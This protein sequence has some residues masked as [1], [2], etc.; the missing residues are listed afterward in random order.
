[1]NNFKKSID[2]QVPRIIEKLGFWLNPVIL[3]FRSQKSKL[4]IFYFHGIY[5]DLQEKKKHHVAPQN[6]IT[7]DQ[8]SEFIE[9][10]LKYKYQFIS[11]KDL[12]GGISKDHRYIM[13]TFD[14]GYFNNTLAL[15]ALKK[16]KVPATFFITTNNLINNQ[17]FWWD[18]VYK[19]RQREGTPL[20]YIQKEQQYLKRFKYQDINKYL[21]DNFGPDCFKSWS[22]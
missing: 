12:D 5:Q 20:N 22:I 9:Y 4:L 11:P 13:I 16:Y 14:D 3:N 18:I 7:V 10:F 21:E 17:S 15:P 2:T 6:N 1:M 8:F 19:Y